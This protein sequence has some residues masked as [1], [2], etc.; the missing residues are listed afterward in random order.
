MFV[1]IGVLPHIRRIII[2]IIII[3]YHNHHHHD[4][5]NYNRQHANDPQL[6]AYIL[7]LS[8]NPQ[9]QQSKQP[10]VLFCSRNNIVY[11]KHIGRHRHACCVMI[12]AHLTEQSSV[13]YIYIQECTLHAVEQVHIMC[14]FAL[15]CVLSWFHKSRFDDDEFS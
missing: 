2:I 11:C 5:Q 4:Q 14:M 13:Q 8:Q 15:I 10:D 6:Y 7:A 9:R 1:Y 12:C 3:T